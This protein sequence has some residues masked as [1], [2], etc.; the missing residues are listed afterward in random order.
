MKSVKLP[1]DISI[2][3][4]KAIYR[5]ISFTQLV[6]ILEMGKFPLL[7]INQKWDDP[8]EGVIL[9]MMVEA[10]S[11]NSKDKKMK[12][13]RNYHKHIYGTCWSTLSESDAMWRI[14]SPYKE[15]VRI[16]TSVGKLKRVIESLDLCGTSATGQVLYD[17]QKYP[18]SEDVKESPLLPSYFLKE[19]AF[20]HEKEVRAVVYWNDAK[21]KSFPEVILLSL[22]DGF[23]EDVVID[24]RASG[25]F[26]KTVKAY[27]TNKKNGSC[28][29]SKLYEEKTFSAF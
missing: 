22:N 4:D 11:S 15:G 3:D 25:W 27:Y 26:E 18:T 7:N 1:G 23:I 16:K 28:E 20:F 2:D 19:K 5:Y 17:P 6:S 9:R 14:Y 12:E 21:Q 10:G 13:I 24:P 8:N 29:K